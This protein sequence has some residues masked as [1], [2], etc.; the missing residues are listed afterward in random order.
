MSSKSTTSEEPQERAH[1]VRAA[2]SQL[3]LKFPTR[4]NKQFRASLLLCVTA[5][6]GEFSEAQVIRLHEAA[7]SADST[8]DDIAALR[9]ALQKVLGRRFALRSYRQ[10]S[11]SAE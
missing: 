4:E 11:T 1:L 10:P 9:S 5:R 3:G 2:V 6:L 8:D 7:C